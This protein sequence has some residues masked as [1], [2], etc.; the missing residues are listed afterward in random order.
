MNLLLNF[1]NESNGLITKLKISF[2]LKKIKYPIS[3]STPHHF[4]RMECL[5][6]LSRVYIQP[7][8]PKA[9]KSARETAAFF[10][11]QRQTFRSRLKIIIYKNFLIQNISRP[12]QTS[13]IISNPHHFP[14]ME[15]LK[16]S[17]I[18]NHC[19]S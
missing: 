2:L 10:G 6:I 3:L 16:I 4:P 1:N 7:L 17:S 12:P 11:T 14:R 19:A 9:S 18:F 15:Y 5:K 13:N 8:H